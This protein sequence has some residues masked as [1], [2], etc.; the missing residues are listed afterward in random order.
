MPGPG[1]YSYNDSVFGV[2]KPPVTNAVQQHIK[3]KHG[4]I[5]E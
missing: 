5:I 4:V 3:K 2:P 1:T